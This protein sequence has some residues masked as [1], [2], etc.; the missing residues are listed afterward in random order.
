MTVVG[1]CRRLARILKIS[2]AS[3]WP[4]HQADEGLPFAAE[5]SHSAYRTRQMERVL[6]DVDPNRA[7][8]IQ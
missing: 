7:D 6:A 4:G 8:G 2:R 3:A 5:Q 1:Q